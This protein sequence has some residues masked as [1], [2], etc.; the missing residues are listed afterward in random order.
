[1]NQGTIHPADCRCSKCPA[2]RNQRPAS[3]RLAVGLYV[4]VLVIAF[5][6]IASMVAS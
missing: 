2:T 1:V 5:A 6:L 3:L 4:L